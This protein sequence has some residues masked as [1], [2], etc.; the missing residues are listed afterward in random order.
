M[1]FS[2]AEK[3]LYF[4]LRRIRFDSHR[5]RSIAACCGQRRVLF[6]SAFT[7][8]RKSLDKSLHMLLKTLLAMLFSGSVHTSHML[9]DLSSDMR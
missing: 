7:L 2:L 4:Y 1:L 3:P 8:G 5:V 6:Y 9:S